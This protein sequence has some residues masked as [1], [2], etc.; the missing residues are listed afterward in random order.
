MALPANLT[1]NLRNMLAQFRANNAF[2]SIPGGNGKALEAWVM[3]RLA[4]AAAVS[5][6]WHVTLRR[7]DETPL[8]PGAQFPFPSAQHEIEPSSPSAAGYI[9]LQDLL[10]GYDLEL[11][12]SLRWGGR[13][14][15]THEIDISVIPAAIASTLRA[16]AGGLPRGLPVLAVECKD[17]A[18]AG[19]A[20]EMRE[21][22]ARLFDLAL[23]TKPHA[24]V[25]CRVFAKST[26]VTSTW[27]R[28]G[29]RSGTYKAFFKKGTF[30]VARVGAFRLGARCMADHFHIQ[31]IGN[32][33]EPGL[34]HMLTL[35]RHF[36]N[37][38]R[39]IHKL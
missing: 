20:D 27:P 18:S 21:T 14:N 32:I 13:S 12:S 22:L 37:T 31:Q 29:R 5:S 34:R 1:S 11:H 39:L 26:T 10:E 24:S 28:W 2:T 9:H 7:G 33:Y 8:P 19:E 38:L 36:Q 16:A 6:R 15:A 35:E 3:F 4:T 30:A 25:S 23:V 17:K